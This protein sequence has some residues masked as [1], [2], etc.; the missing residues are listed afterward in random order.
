MLRSFVAF[1]IALASGAHAVSTLLAQ[2]AAGQAPSALRFEVASIRP[3]AASNGGSVVS[4]KGETFRYTNGSLA[5]IIRF[6]YGVGSP[7]AAG[8]AILAP[9][10]ERPFGEVEGLPDWA[11]SR[12]DID[13]K[14]SGSFGELVTR[15]VGPIHVM[16]QSLLIERFKLATHWETRE[17]PAY[18]LIRVPG[19]APLGPGIRPVDPKICDEF[20]AAVRKARLE[21]ASAPAR[22]VKQNPRMPHCGATS[23]DEWILIDGRSMRQ[24]ADVFAGRLRQPVADETGLEGSFDI[25]LSLRRNS[26]IAGD[27]AQALPN[28]PALAGQLSLP[29]AVREQPAP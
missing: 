16:L 23:Y 17:R 27:S 8:A 12:Y 7:G 3:S 2:D 6:A 4:Y 14:T 10:Y 22:P 24:I 26:S 25:E 19:N 1:I 28:A 20:L 15:T 18:A 21:G 9:V 5:D 29:D 11:T 13:A